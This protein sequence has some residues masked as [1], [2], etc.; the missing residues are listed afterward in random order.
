MMRSARPKRKSERAVRA[1]PPGVYFLRLTLAPDAASV[2]TPFKLSV[3][4]KTP[5]KK[6]L[7]LL[8]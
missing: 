4:G 2:T 1:L 3:L 8:A 7:S 6:D 5:S